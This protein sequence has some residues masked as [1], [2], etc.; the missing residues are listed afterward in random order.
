MIE[1]RRQGKKMR[2]IA[3]SMPSR[4]YN[5]LTQRIWKLRG[6]KEGLKT[7]QLNAFSDEEGGRITTLRQS[8]Q[9]WTQIAQHLPG[10]SAKSISAHYVRLTRRQSAATGRIRR[11]RY[12]PYED[13]TILRL[14][15][16]SRMI[17]RDIG[18]EVGRSASSVRNRYAGLLGADEPTIIP[19]RNRLSEAEVE[20]IVS[21]R[22]AGMTL[23]AIGDEIG[24]SHSTV[25][26]A[27]QRAT[28]VTSTKHT[29]SRYTPAED[30]HLSAMLSQGWKPADIAKSMDR[31]SD[32]VS[33][34]IH[35][36]RSLGR[37]KGY[38]S[39]TGARSR[40]PVEAQVSVLENRK[41]DFKSDCG[42]KWI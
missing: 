18:K 42:G 21:L 34:R 33:R 26:L 11:P 25:T 23:H 14:R 41:E 30:A 1:M 29:M 16:E 37:L 22:D 39:R 24:R 12:S 28:R 4:S 35:A 17:W 8:G 10:R 9:T 31:H 15:D 27:Y 40:G 38:E 7:L 2:E 20:Q 36:L 5:A 32:S 6:T 13:A 3:D 19:P